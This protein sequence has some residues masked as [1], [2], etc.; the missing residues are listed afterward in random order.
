VVHAF[1]SDC[2]K[3]NCGKPSKGSAIFSSDGSAVLPATLLMDKK[4]LDPY[5]NRSILSSDISLGYEDS[6]QPPMV[7]KGSLVEM[8]RQQDRYHNPH[9]LSIGFIVDKC[10]SPHYNRFLTINKSPAI[11]SSTEKVPCP[12]I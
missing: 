1:V 3:P 4:T 7:T 12:K 5:I 11:L 9:C 6:L 8:D 10:Q 2:S